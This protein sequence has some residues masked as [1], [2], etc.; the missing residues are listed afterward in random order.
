MTDSERKVLR[1][2]ELALESETGF[3][4]AVECHSYQ[5]IEIDPLL[6]EAV[7]AVEHFLEDADIR[8]RDSEYHRQQRERLEKL[9]DKIYAR[10]VV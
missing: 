10:G 3:E 6:A 1:L 9:R 7:H 4:E 2:I 8:V 5:N